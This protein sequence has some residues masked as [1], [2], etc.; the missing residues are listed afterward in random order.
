MKRLNNEVIQPPLK[1]FEYLISGTAIANAMLNDHLSDWIKENMNIENEISPTLQY[2]FSQGNMFEQKIIELI[3]KK[4]K[5]VRISPNNRYAPHLIKSTIDELEK[6]TPIIFS[7]PLECK[8][9]CGTA[10]ILIRS[11]YIN[12]LC[13]NTISTEESKIGCR[14]NENY[15]Y[16]VIDIKYSTIPLR[17]DFK[18]ILNEDRY[19][20]YKGQVW[21]YNEILS[22]FQNYNPNI[23]YIL[24]RGVTC[25]NVKYNSAFDKL[26]VVDFNGIDNDIPL[27]V[28]NACN[29]IHK[30]KSNGSNMTY[31]NCVELYPNMNIKTFNKQKQKLAT[32]IGEITQLW[33]CGINE[34]NIAFS[35]QIYSFKD[36][37][38]NASI[39]NFTGEKGKILDTMLEL[40][41][42]NIKYKKINDFSL[43]SQSLI[44]TYFIDFET[45]SGIFDDFSKLPIS[46]SIDMIFMI[47][48]VWESDRQL[49]RK[50]FCIDKMDK[51][52]E[53]K[54]LKSFSDFVGSN[55]YLYHWGNAEV[56]Q[57]NKA[58]QKYSLQNTFNW[59]DLFELFKKTVV[60]KNCF[61]Y[62]LKDVIFKLIEYNLID[63]EWNSSIT[64][65]EDAMILAF[66]EFTKYL[67]LE[68]SPILQNIAQY[69]QLDCV[70]VY[71]I[72]K[73]LENI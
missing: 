15:H 73:F 36:D 69:N 59:V 54:I 29:W 44:T 30:L 52:E 53:E 14:F 57:W 4:I 65:G 56:S 68:N 27:K 61:S 51:K 72:L 31:E 62:S 70:A 32:H 45:F 24:G 22:N 23:S 26:G 47:S 38:F 67:T 33:N 1:K 25:K 66:H 18:H 21:I 40:Y 43:P 60:I 16:R 71:K 12:I 64:N 35:K 19:P 9:L 48:V 55:A 20:A 10:D 63:F 7:A 3:S 46:N 50:T 42:T 13:P 39:I 17:A 2:L 5:V 49:Q 8:G 28:K 37:R 11:D 6:G 41:K 34:R 58:V